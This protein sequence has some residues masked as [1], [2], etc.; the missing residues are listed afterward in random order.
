MNTDIFIK[1][2]SDLHSNFYTYEKSI[3]ISNKTPIIITCPIHGDFL[4]S[5]NNH[6]SGYRCMKCSIDQRK[7]KRKSSN[8]IER[9]K[10]KFNDKFGYTDVIYVN[11]NTNI[12]IECNIHGYISILPN[13]H[14]KSKTGCSLC[15]AYNTAKLQRLDKNDLILRFID[16]HKSKYNYSNISYINFNSK[17]EILCSDHGIF[18][19]T[20]KRHLQGSGCP[21]CICSKGEN[22]IL[23]ILNENNIKF[24]TQHTFADCFYKRPLKFDFYL[25][26]RNIVIEYDGEQHFQPLSIFGGEKSFELQKIKDEIKNKFCEK[27]NIKMYRIKY[28]DDINKK[29][30]EIID[31]V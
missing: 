26:T 8:F 28:N 14:L 21:R 12:K 1:K 31:E 4:Q 3:Y 17:I 16:V 13:V 30:T 18:W 5:P 22:K 11:N 25:P 20:P 29:L 6:L 23:N 10:L 19:Q 2:S 9:S 7:N 24:T 15:S 27:K